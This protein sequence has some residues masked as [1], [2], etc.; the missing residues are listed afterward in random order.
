M[1]LG[2]AAVAPAPEP[3]ERVVRAARALRGGSVVTTGDVTVTE[4]PRSALPEGALGD[5]HQVVGRIL[6]GPRAP[7]EVLTDAAVLTSATVGPGRAIAPVRVADT[8][9]GSLLHVGDRVDVLAADGQSPRASLVAADVR[10]LAVPAS[11]SD[12]ATGALVLLD[13]D[14]PT[15]AAL[16]QAAASAT[17]TV[18]WR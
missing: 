13:V 3:S 5:P 12:S 7:G 14:R 16:A 11:E 15:A 2:L 10:V 18:T 17:V 6:S 9:L 1:L 4:V 8:T